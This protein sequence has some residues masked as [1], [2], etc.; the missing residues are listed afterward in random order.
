MLHRNEP[1]F[2]QAA[3]W[4]HV[5]MQLSHFAFPKWHFHGLAYRTV[6]PVTSFLSVIVVSSTGNAIMQLS[7]LH[8]GI[9]GRPLPIRARPT[10]ATRCEPP[11]NPNTSFRTIPHTS[12][13]DF[14]ASAYGGAEC[15]GSWSCFMRCFS[16][17]S[18]S[19]CLLRLCASQ[20]LIRVLSIIM[21]TR[22]R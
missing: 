9:S 12:S 7:Q 19:P 10:V 21:P 15:S 20:A 16:D 5:C 4:H 14:A 6:V 8:A 13:F 3:S 22:G 18:T 2:G 11:S 1:V 17:A